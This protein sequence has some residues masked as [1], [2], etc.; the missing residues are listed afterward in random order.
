M[1]DRKELMMLSGRLYPD[2]V[3]LRREIHK[4]PELSGNEKKTAAL[5]ARELKKAGLKPQ[6]HCGKTAVSAAIKNG[7]GPTVVLRSDIDALP[8]TEKSHLPFASVNNGVMH[9]CGHDLHAAMLLAA[10]PAL[11]RL[12]D[13]WQGTAVLL[14]QPSE[15]HEPGGAQALIR[16]G[17]FP[18]NASAVFGMHVSSDHPVGT[19]GLRPGSDY[20]GVLNYAV[21]VRGRGGHAAAPNETIDPI[22]CASVIICAIKALTNTHS[23]AAE[24]PAVVA[25][26]RISA[27]T[28]DNIVPDIARFSGTI[29]THSKKT[30]QYIRKQID[31][32]VRL[33]DKTFGSQSTIE[34]F[35]GYPPT[36]NDP[37]LTKKIRPV[38]ANAAFV[39][40]R[41]KPN[42]FA[43]D[44]AYYQQKAPGI[45][46]HLGVKPPGQTAMP[47]IHNAA[48]SP[49]ERAM[50]TGIAAHVAFVLAMLLVPRKR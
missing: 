49:D 13:R 24:H 6:F 20:A 28:A 40:L 32:V 37:A 2:A 30:E 11:V 42:F 18:E 1:I 25:I 23:R 48:F 50:K 22:V 16:A 31:G 39:V 27:G 41:K 35:R 29:R 12:R 10:A 17:A 44:F 21:T 5:I 47:G 15:E 19:I 45:Y 7:E 14:F 3:R 43:E 33:A 38:L 4:Y 8:I 34:F 36:W 9:A 26:G 46:V